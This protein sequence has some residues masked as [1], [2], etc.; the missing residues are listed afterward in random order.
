MLIKKLFYFYI[1]SVIFV[2][3]NKDFDVVVGEKAGDG[4]GPLNDSNVVWVV[5]GFG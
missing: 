2:I 4:V 1:A 3:I 5:D